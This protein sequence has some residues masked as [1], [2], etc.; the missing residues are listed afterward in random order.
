MSAVRFGVFVVISLVSVS[1]LAQA[2][3]VFVGSWTVQ[4]DPYHGI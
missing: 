2:P 3:S 4:G 1:A